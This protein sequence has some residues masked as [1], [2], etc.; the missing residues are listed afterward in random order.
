MSLVATLTT[1]GLIPKVVEWTDYE[2][3]TGSHSYGVATKDSDRDVVSVT[4]PPKTEIFPHLM[5]EIAEINVTV[6]HKFRSFQKHHMLVDGIKTDLTITSFQHFL[7][8]LFP[9]NPNI[10]DMMFAPDDCV[11]HASKAFREFLSYRRAILTQESFLRFR[12][13]GASQIYKLQNIK[14][15]NNRTEL[16]EKHGYDVKY[17]YHAFRLFSQARQIATEGDLNLRDP[18]RIATM[19]YIREG[20]YSLEEFHSLMKEEGDKLRAAE[21][22]CRLPKKIDKIMARDII[23]RTLEVKFGSLEGLVSKCLS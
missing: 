8:S 20:A 1:R 11:I 3:V 2:I 4:I 15:H 7:N 17:A 6:R 5:G 16:V 19:R 23:Y 22:S 13:Y 12:K 21:E 10:V 18:Q 14:S 9:N